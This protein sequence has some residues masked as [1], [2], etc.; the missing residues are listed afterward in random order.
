MGSLANAGTGP[1]QW[2]T[3]QQ[4][5]ANWIAFMGSKLAVSPVPAM[6]AAADLTIAQITSNLAKATLAAHEAY[7]QEENS[8]PAILVAPTTVSLTTWATV[9]AESAAMG[10]LA[11]LWQLF[12]GYTTLQAEW[13][14]N[15]SGVVQPSA[16]PAIPLTLVP[17]ELGVPAP[18]AG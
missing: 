15:N 13:V 1:P 9:N 18:V 2:L 3:F 10:S 5:V 17:W 11:A 12:I 16:M 4:N 6:S 14:A 7:E 8:N